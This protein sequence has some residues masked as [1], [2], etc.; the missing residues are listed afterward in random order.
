MGLCLSWEGNPIRAPAPPFIINLLQPLDSA[1]SF[2]LPWEGLG[3]EG[4]APAGR[5][6]ALPS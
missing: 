3:V 2:H 5:M 4:G 1:L 6:V